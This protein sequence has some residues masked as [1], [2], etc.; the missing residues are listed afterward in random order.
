M[1]AVL[2]LL[3]LRRAK[4]RILR[5]LKLLTVSMLL[6][7]VIQIRRANL[8]TEVSANLHA[9]DKPSTF[10]TCEDKYKGILDGHSK[11]KAKR[12][13][14]AALLHNNAEIMEYWS[15]S[16]LQLAR[17]FPKAYVS[18]FESNSFDET[19]SKLSSL[20]EQLVQYKIGNTIISGDQGNLLGGLPFAPGDPSTGN[21]ISHLARLRNLALQPLLDQRARGISYQKVIFL[22]DVL[23]CFQ[24]IVRLLSHEAD[25]SCGYDFNGPVFWD[26]WVM[27]YGSTDYSLHSCV[28]DSNFEATLACNN[29][30]PLPVACC[31]N[32][33][34]VFEA[35]II[36][37]GVRF[38]RGK[39][40]AECSNSECSIFCRD[41]RAKGFNRV[42][43]DPSI[44]VAY[45]T[46]FPQFRRRL[47]DKLPGVFKTENFS[48]FELQ[49]ETS[50]C[51]LA[52][53]GQQYVDWDKCFNMPTENLVSGHR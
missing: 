49:A 14:I 3:D 47:P 17:A 19:P 51:E 46:N 5:W 30:M 38:R 22:N 28:R 4:H 37:Q 21:R 12:I 16:V 35:E 43:V 53:D 1:R 23:F 40:G 29:S 32:G 7:Y 50:C 31:W 9:F 42:V 25:I 48:S 39:Q 10:V 52:G 44:Q 27:D 8:S 2:G 34:A 13:F 33:A 6:V 24:D 26:N 45:D 36:Y 11:L 18:I 15:R 20:K 41:A